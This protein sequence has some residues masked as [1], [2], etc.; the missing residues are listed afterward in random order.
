[1]GAICRNSKDVATDDFSLGTY[2]AKSLGSDADWVSG[3]ELGFAAGPCYGGSD[4]VSTWSPQVYVNYGLPVPGALHSF[5]SG[6]KLSYYHNLF[7]EDF[8]MRLTPSVGTRVNFNGGDALKGWSGMAL[9][10][11][12]G[13]FWQGDG[14]LRVEPHVGV[15]GTTSGDYG[16]TTGVNFGWSWW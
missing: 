15:E 4:G 2:N 1:M 13:V 14:G 7:N 6:V 8:G 11:D 9:G 3:F 5:S 10:V 16:I 12:T